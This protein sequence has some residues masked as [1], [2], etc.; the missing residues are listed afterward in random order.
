MVGLDCVTGAK[1][2]SPH[3]VL[4]GP[5]LVTAIWQLEDSQNQFAFKKGMAPPFIQ[6]TIPSR[7]S[8]TLFPFSCFVRKLESCSCDHIGCPV[9]TGYHWSC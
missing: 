7:Y 9:F 1:A 4:W 6:P 2:P 3:W 8:H 5:D